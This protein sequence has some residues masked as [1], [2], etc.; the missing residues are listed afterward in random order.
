[1]FML[2]NILTR[3]GAIMILL[4]FS[5]MKDYV[6]YQAKGRRRVDL[7]RSETSLCVFQE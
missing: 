4:E 2:F 1:M 7:S 6:Q 5:L 3:I